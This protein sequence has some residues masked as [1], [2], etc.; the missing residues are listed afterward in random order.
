M[1]HQMFEVRL[2]YRN[3]SS[4]PLL[5]Y[6]LHC[7]QGSPIRRIGSKMFVIYHLDPEVTSKRAHMRGFPLE[8]I[9]YGL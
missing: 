1:K 8:H 2:R 9:Y 6:S 7:F 3:V 5:Q 4:H